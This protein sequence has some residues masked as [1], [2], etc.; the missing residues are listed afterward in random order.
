MLSD[1]NKIK[2][3]S[4]S[5][6]FLARF[7]PDGKANRIVF[8]VGLILLLL[9]AYFYVS[10]KSDSTEKQ[11]NRLSADDYVSQT[12]DRLE[13]ILSEIRGVG[14]CSVLITLESGIEYVYAEEEKYSSDSLSS[15]NR[16]EAGENRQKSYVTTKTSGE[17]TPVVV[18]EITPSVKGV[19]VI[20]DGGGM[21]AVKSVVTEMISKA[22]GIPGDKIAIAQRNG[23]NAAP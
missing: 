13:E 4:S 7:L 22:L 3:S 5:G 2:Q 1:Q 10:G 23:E 8:A 20:C 6:T 12:E 11:K 16:T 19:A 15:E 9:V 17:E 21:P 14:Q 18:T